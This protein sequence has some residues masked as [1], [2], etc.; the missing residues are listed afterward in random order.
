MREAG[1]YGMSDRPAPTITGGGTETGGAE[2]IAHLDRYTNREDWCWA[3]PSTTVVGSFKPEVIAAPGYRTT[4]SRQ[5][6]EGSVRVTVEEAGILQSFPVD[7]PWQGPRTK[8]Y[9]QVG[10]AVPPL[11]ALAALSAITGIDIHTEGVA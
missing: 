3:R 5:N 8:Q 7:H 6:A 9:L 4:V 10:N 2:P 1:H 11:L